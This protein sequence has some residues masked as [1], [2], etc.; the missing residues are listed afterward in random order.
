L[1]AQRKRIKRKGSQ[2]LAA[3]LLIRDADYLA[4]LAKSGR[5]GKS[6]SLY[7]LAG[8]SAESFLPFFA[9]LLSFVKWHFSIN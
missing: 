4:L 8:Y 2:S 5:F 3:S 1:F 6:H 9:V 7:P